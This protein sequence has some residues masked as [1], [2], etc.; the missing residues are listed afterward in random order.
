MSN[1]VDKVLN[2]KRIDADDVAALVW[3]QVE[4]SRYKWISEYYADPKA[5]YDPGNAY[6]RS[7]FEIDSVLY[8]IDWHEQDYDNSFWEREDDEVPQ[9]FKVKPITIEKTVYVKV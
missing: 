6:Y 8:A 2:G 4:D 7:V 3:N 1:V 9:P 5:T